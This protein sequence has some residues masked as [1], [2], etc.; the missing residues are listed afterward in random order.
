MSKRTADGEHRTYETGLHPDPSVTPPDDA[1]MI[2]LGASGDLTR[3]KLV[4]AL[5]QLYRS[6]LMPGRFA[7]IGVARRPYDDPSFRERLREG[8]RERC[9]PQDEEDRCSEFLEHVEY[10]R[11]DLEAPDT[12]AS[13][14][15][16]LDR[17][18]DRYPSGRL[19]YFSLKP[20]L[21]IEA[22]HHL[23]EHG[24]IDSDS[25]AQAGEGAW[26]RAVIEKPFG[27]DLESARALNRALLEGLDE[28]QIFRIDHYVGKEAVQNV[29]AFRF[30][31]T[32][33]E[34]VL[35]RTCVDHIQLTA[36]EALGVGGGRGGYYDRYG[37]IR[38][39]LSNHL[40]Q[41]LALL[42]ME[43]PSGL[44]SDAIHNEKTKVLKA[45]RVDWRGDA[46]PAFCRAQY[47][48]GVMDDGTRAVGYRDEDRVD[49]DSE[50]ESY[51]AVRLSI[52]N[53]RW[54]GVPVFVRTGKRMKRKLTEVAVHFRH[55]PLKLFRGVECEG[56]HCDVR[57]VQPNKLIFRIQPQEGI[58]LNMAVKRPTLPFVVEQADMDFSYAG[59]WGRELPE[60]YE[61]L[62]L[63]ALR[64]DTT[65][66]TR[67]DEVE[68]GWS[69]VEPV[70]KAMDRTPLYS[71][72][73]GSWGPAEAD[74]LFQ[75]SD[76]PDECLCR[77]TG[78][79]R[80]WHNPQ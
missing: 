23:R 77:K 4:P 17:G 18:G 67:S 57:G 58:F 45:L 21:F 54:S 25:A 34:P 69:V 38:D 37:A 42:T 14:R 64:G 39:M 72:P 55:P 60:A 32:L 63:D 8:I 66:F 19:F 46:S 16:H 1:V 65:L 52:D 15:D 80:A 31:N 50:T 2:L 40:L 48:A 74:R 62:L 35:N 59:K 73:A 6:G 11:G 27:H 7:I 26:R 33:F 71:Y 78:L 28:K 36:A 13:L 70:L 20:D 24:L 30:A 12:Y 47:A 10:F 79:V 61:R 29:M 44:D 3:R 68:A 5:F 51:A 43:P 41:L 75:C 9:A 53:W 76:L 49:R 56:A 22:A